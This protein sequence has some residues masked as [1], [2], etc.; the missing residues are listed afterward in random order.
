MRYLL[1]SAFML[2]VL[3]SVTA[4]DDYY[5]PIGDTTWQRV[6]L[7][8]LG[9]NAA[10]VDS[11]IAYA[12]RTLSNS[13]IV[14]VGGRIAIEWYADGR[15]ATSPWYWASAGKTV[16]ATLVGVLQQEGKLS[17]NDA[18]SKYLGSG[19]TSLTPEQEA[20]ITI[21]NQLTMTSGLDD[22]VADPYCTDKTCLQYKAEPGTR[23][24]YHNAPYTLLDGVIEAASGQ[25][26]QAVLNR[27]LLDKTGMTG[28]FIAS[29]Y[30]NV[31]WSTPR[32]MA[33]F[34]L[35]AQR[36]FIWDGTPI[37][38]DTSYVNALTRPSQP[39][40]PSYGYLWWLNGQPT[41]KLPG[42]QID[43]KGPALPDA[44]ADAFNALGKNNQ[45]ISVSPSMNI[46]MVRTGDNPDS[47]LQGADVA[48]T[49]ANDLWRLLR[50]AMPTS[51]ID[52]DEGGLAIHGH[53]V[54]AN[55][56]SIGTCVITSVTGEQVVF[57]GGNASAVEL[58]ALARG[59]YLLQVQL[60]GQT[61]VRRWSNL[62]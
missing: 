6:S 14:L 2:S 3:S 16:T 49:Q 62:R 61:V 59:V 19:W 38:T 31:M 10:R 28:R 34:G 45:M 52:A 48:T 50:A 58:P 30:N 40:N 20:R 18:T 37:L 56:G 1:I 57:E 44:P 8:D 21:W 15:T 32:S 43:F 51:H 54:H 23:W 27:S 22:R 26:F 41:Y 47:L 36:R 9:W 42:L 12:E 11:L 13:L 17:V 25:T 60:D 24:A 39:L 4:Q 35:L 33:R 5:P 29:G 46:V 55:S 53:T 7:Q